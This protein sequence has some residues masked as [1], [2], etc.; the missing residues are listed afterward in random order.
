M[1]VPKLLFFFIAFLFLPMSLEDFREREVHDFF[2]FLPYVSFL[3]TFM[4][5]FKAGLLATILGAFVFIVTFVLYK[6][7]LL[8]E[9][10]VIGAP[11][12]FSFPFA[13]EYISFALVIVSTL[14]IAYSYLKRKDV[15]HLPLVG[16]IGLAVFTGLICFVLFNF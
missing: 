6:Q 2:L 4:L 10:D 5:S 7:K 11:L 3:A 14:H 1:T 8:A 12:L 16:Y 15:N 9:G 13:L